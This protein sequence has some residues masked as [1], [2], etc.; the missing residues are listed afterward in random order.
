[1]APSK[2]TT[3]QR[4][5]KKG[6]VNVNASV[7]MMELI[8]KAAHVPS[9]TLSSQEDLN[10]IQDMIFGIQHQKFNVEDVI[11]LPVVEDKGLEDGLTIAIGK[12][13]YIFLTTIGFTVSMSLTLEDSSMDPQELL[14]YAC[15]WLTAF[16][17][18]EVYCL[19]FHHQ[20]KS[21][22]FFLG[23]DGMSEVSSYGAG[24]DYFADLSL[25]GTK[26]SHKERG[27]DIQM[28]PIHILKED[29]PR[30]IAKMEAANLTNGFFDSLT[31]SLYESLMDD[32]EDDEDLDSE[33][34]EVL[35]HL[36]K[37]DESEEEDLQQKNLDS[38]LDRIEQGNRKKERRAPK[39]K[40]N[41]PIID[42][43]FIESVDESDSTDGS[44]NSSKKN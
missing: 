29:D 31:S 11:Y 1:M 20:D 36:F 22:V 17:R 33:F 24:L 15:E 44:T 43:E 12:Q 4:K 32:E 18:N 23:P 40:K 37:E 27:M 39:K 9:Y 6:T 42:V 21:L 28:I 16:T 41:Q 5:T 34:T 30:F 10:Q 3:S 7:N 13:G 26:A 14:A 8:L 35:A 38:L 25:I 2:K 19:A